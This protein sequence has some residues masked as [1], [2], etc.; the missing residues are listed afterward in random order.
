MRNSIMFFALSKSGV[1][2][3]GMVKTL[4]SVRVLVLR[5]LVLPLEGDLKFKV[6]ENVLAV[7]RGK[8]FKATIPIIA[9]TE[10]YLITDTFSEI[11]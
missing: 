5:V 11:Q 10:R 4:T 3:N 2:S 1:S 8:Q 9:G 7:H 6:G